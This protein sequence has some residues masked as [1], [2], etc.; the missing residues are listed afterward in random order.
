[1]KRNTTL[2]MAGIT[3]ELIPS[4]VWL[5]SKG[6]NVTV[7]HSNVVFS[8]KDKSKKIYDYTNVILFFGRRLC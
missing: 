2:M 1:M 7:T 6:N 4:G 5:V 8:H 3:T